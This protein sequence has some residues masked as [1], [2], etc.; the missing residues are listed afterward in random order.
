LLR[1]LNKRANSATWRIVT[2][3]VI[4]KV[5]H[6]LRRTALRHVTN[7]RCSLLKAARS[8]EASSVSAELKAH[9]SAASSGTLSANTLKTGFRE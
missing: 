9:L 5:C 6:C 3:E 8:W 2:S 1:K 4:L 7:P